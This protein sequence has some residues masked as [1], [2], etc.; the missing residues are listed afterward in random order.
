[1]GKFIMNRKEREQAHAFRTI[2][3]SKAAMVVHRFFPD[4]KLVNGIYIMHNNVPVA[5]PSPLIGAKWG[6]VSIKDSLQ[7][8]QRA[9]LLLDGCLIP[10]AIVLDNPLNTC[11]RPPLFVTICIR[12]GS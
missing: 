7:P 6:I 4:V 2:Q 1:M 9:Q 12:G 3:A 5:F 8:W 11:L 10:G